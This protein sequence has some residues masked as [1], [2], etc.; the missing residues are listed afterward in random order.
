MNARQHIF[1][2]SATGHLGAYRAAAI[3][4]CHRLGLLPV[5]IRL[6]ILGHDHPDTLTTRHDTADWRGE[7]GDPAASVTSA[8]RDGP[9]EHGRQA[10][11]S[12]RDRPGE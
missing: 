6:R 10:A 5:F 7:A 9:R 2:A 1:V 12:K 4:V 3:E 11:H 8:R